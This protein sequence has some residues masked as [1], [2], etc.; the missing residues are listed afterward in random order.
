[1]DPKPGRLAMPHS[2]GMSCQRKRASCG[3]PCPLACHPGPCPPCSTLIVQPCYCG[4]TT[5]SLRC[6]RMVTPGGMPLACGATCNRTL[7]CGNHRCTGV[8]HPGECLPCT[9]QA[10][11]KCYCGRVE[12]ILK[13]GAGKDRECSDGQQKW[14][15]RFSCE[16]NCDR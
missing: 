7:Q 12:H 13:C 15:G 5:I 1:V 10:N 2:C 11:S 4:S 6:S 14:T 3:H 16:D 9:H 8:C